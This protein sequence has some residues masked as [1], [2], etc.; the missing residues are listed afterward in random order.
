M[1]H[2]LLIAIKL[3]WKYITESKRRKCLFKESCSNYVYKKTNEEGLV[4][5]LKALQFRI[6][7]C[8][9]NYNIIEVD[10]K[11]LLI[12]STYLVLNESEI[13]HSILNP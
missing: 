1:K 2:L 3:Y 8:N 13:N 4:S 12:S 10:N 9:S 6:H 7:N 5:G 11:K